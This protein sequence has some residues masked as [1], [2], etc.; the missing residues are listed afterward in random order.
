MG[1]K[2]LKKKGVIWTFVFISV[3]SGLI[4]LDLSITGGAIESNQN[5]TDPV[6]IIGLLLI[7]CSVVLIIYSAKKK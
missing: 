5:S 4:F 7:L 2:N 3:I 6:S 1:K